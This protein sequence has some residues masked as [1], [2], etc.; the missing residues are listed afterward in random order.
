MGVILVPINKHTPLNKWYFNTVI[1]AAEGHSLAMNDSGDEWNVYHH[2]NHM[3]AALKN[4]A[5]LWAPIQT[6]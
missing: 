1:Y 5:V 6:F 3:G 4:T 2:K